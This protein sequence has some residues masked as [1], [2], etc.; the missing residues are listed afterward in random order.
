MRSRTCCRSI[1]SALAIL[2]STCQAQPLPI[3]GPVRPKSPGFRHATP[4]YSAD[5]RFI[6]ETLSVGRP[7]PYEGGS[8]VHYSAT[9]VPLNSGPWALE[10]W[11]HDLQTGE[12]FILSSGKA[13]SWGGTWDRRGRRLVYLSDQDGEAG[14]WVWDRDSYSSRRIGQAIP[15]VWLGNGP[16]YWLSDGAEILCA[17]LPEGASLASMTE[18]IADTRGIHRFEKGP[19][20]APSVVVYRAGP[21][22]PPVTTRPFDRYR[23]DLGLLEV[24]TG[25]VRRLVKDVSALWYGPS[26]D[27][28][29]VAYLAYAGHMPNTQQQLYTLRVVTLATGA[30]EVIAAGIA[31]ASPNVVSWSPTNDAIA[32][33][34]G[35]QRGVPGCW[36]HRFTEGATQEVLLPKAEPLQQIERAPSWSI[37]G[38]T[39]YLVSGSKVWQCLNGDPRSIL[40]LPGRNIRELITDRDNCIRMPGQLIAISQSD[41]PSEIHFDRLDLDTLV[42]ASIVKS[43]LQ[44][45]DYYPA[46]YSAARSEVTFAADS[47]TESMSRWRLSLATGELRR[48]ASLNPEL[49]N[50][51]YGEVRIID[52]Q[53][54]DGE[55]LRGAVLMP[56][57]ATPGRRYPLVVW[58]YGGMRGSERANRLGFWSHLGTLCN[59][60]V[61]ATRGFAVLFPDAPLRPGR[62]VEDLVR[63]IVPGV[64]RA[65]D[66]GFADAKRVAVMGQS[67]GGYSAIA[68]ATHTDRFAACLISAT[69]SVNLLSTY[70]EMDFGGEHQRSGYYEAGQGNMLATPWENFERYRENSP[71]FQLDRIKTPVL[72]AHGSVDTVLPRNSE[73]LFLALKRLHKVAELRI[74]ENEGHLIENPA[75]AHDL[76]A[77]R[78]SFLAEHMD[79]SYAKDGSILF[80]GDRACSRT[81]P[82]EIPK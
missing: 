6:A 39:L 72:I 17:I 53:T 62:S 74:Y 24:A 64:D 52:W 66:L 31:M 58:A 77:R 76:W 61:L 44:Y 25:K 2:A 71:I 60:Q 14:I 73:E 63:T 80:E 35:G 34:A 9:G 46:G 18:Q 10:T 26:P 1:L 13:S 43:R 16:P 59:M 54:A 56:P 50:R 21:S 33:L 29:K 70:F 30:D 22:A 55:K 23:A 8:P 65:I 4:D 15:R 3:D 32:W 38:R 41:E 42:S 5:G 48:A 78:L 57:G 19:Q 27:G 49:E 81:G 20:G 12:K 79:L 7:I 82:Q 11:V 75:N 68:L 47:A 45:A 37:D 40:S 36:V 69:S 51:T 67:Y 28:H